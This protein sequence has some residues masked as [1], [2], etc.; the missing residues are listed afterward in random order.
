MSTANSEYVYEFNAV[1]QQWTSSPQAVQ[2]SINAPCSAYNERTNSGNAVIQVYSTLTNEWITPDNITQP[3]FANS[4]RP[5]SC[6][7]SKCY[8]FGGSYNGET[9]VVQKY[10]ITS[11]EWSILNNTYFYH[12][13][14]N[15][16]S[17]L[18]NDLIYIIGGRCYS[19]EH[20]FAG[21]G[22]MQIFDPKTESIFT[23]NGNLKQNR[24]DVSIII[25]NEEIYV[26]GGGIISENW[27]II[28]YIMKGIGTWC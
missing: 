8:Y 25:Y 15:A 16:R 23:P 14:V 21:C 27:G 18:H 2:I 28:I 10:D 7:N 17:I 20:S 13:M 3:F 12:N 5:C 22:T 11:N 1:T 24:T 6:Y 9:N 19:S 26:I 4:E